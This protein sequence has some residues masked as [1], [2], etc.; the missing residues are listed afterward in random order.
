MRP[1]SQGYFSQNEGRVYGI[2][3]NG[4]GIRWPEDQFVVA[5]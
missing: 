5:S 4:H 2:E 3:H 1:K